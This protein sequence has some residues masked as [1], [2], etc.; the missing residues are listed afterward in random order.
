VYAVNG[1]GIY[2]STQGVGGAWGAPTQHHLGTDTTPDWQTVA[3]VA[4]APGPSINGGASPQ[5]GQQLSATNGSWTG[6]GAVFTYQWSRCDS[7]GNGC[8]NISGAT[9]QTYAVLSADV[10]HTLRVV[11][12]ASNAAG[13]TAS[14]PSNQTGVVTLAGTVNPPVNTV[15]PVITLP[16]GHTAPNI[17]DTLSVSNGTWTGSFPITFTYQWKKCDSP[18]G[19]CF[20]IVGQTRNTFTVT[21]DLYGLTIRAEVTAKNSA[22]AVA[23]N[24]ESTKVVSAIAPL[25]RVTPQITGTVMV[26]QTLALTAGTWD[27]S[28]PLTFT[29]SWRRCNPPGDP[30]SCVQIPGATTATYIPVVDDIGQTIRVWITGT[31]P[32]G[33]DTAITNHTFP[34]VDKPHFA[35]TA[36]DAPLIVGTLEVGGVLTASIG[37]FT[38]DAPIATKQQWQS[39]DATGG[40]CHDIKGATKQIY[41]PTSS[42]VGSTLR[43]V[44]T[45]TNLYR[46][47]LSISDVTEPVIPQLPHVKGETIIGSND[48]DYLIGTPHDDTIKGL[49]GN[50]TINGEAGT[51]RSTAARATT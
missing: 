10:G 8:S 51:T 4:N 7:A 43:L 25:A 1:V 9:V 38:G 29:Y 2:S 13:S 22:A 28:L 33:S 46:K 45:A 42:D 47:A 26:G 50:D 41:H 16:V 3:P 49:G 31:N 39:C 40:A 5:T 18:T 21:S 30:T 14:S 6:A 34:V 48:N 36:G 44:V 11:V 17:G 20:N 19:N 37:T 35:P 15:Y 12:T 32:A 23:Q 24:S 27:G